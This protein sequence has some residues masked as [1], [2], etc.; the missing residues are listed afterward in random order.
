MPLIVIKNVQTTKERSDRLNG[1]K[2]VF[3]KTVYGITAQFYIE[4]FFV[5]LSCTLVAGSGSFLWPEFGRQA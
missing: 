1:E 3:F 2:S 5:S 4:S